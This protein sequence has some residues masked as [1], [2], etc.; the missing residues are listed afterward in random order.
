MK[1]KL[2]NKLYGLEKKKAVKHSYFTRKKC[3]AVAEENGFTIKWDYY[4]RGKHRVTPDERAE[5][6]A[7]TTNEVM[8][9][10]TN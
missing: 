4:G 5:G 1:S 8:E 7:Y 10:I 2:W 6:I 9:R 3:E